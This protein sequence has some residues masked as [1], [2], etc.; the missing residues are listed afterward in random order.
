MIRNSRKRNSKRNT[1]N[2]YVGPIRSKAQALR[3]AKLIEGRAAFIT[4]NEARRQHQAAA[5]MLRESWE[6]VAARP[7]LAEKCCII[8]GLLP[9]GGEPT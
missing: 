5:T 1:M 3:V 9:T 4:D 7:V 6:K 2:K 8:A